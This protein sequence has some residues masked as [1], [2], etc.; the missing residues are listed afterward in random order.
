MTLEEL[1]E[2]LKAHNAN[3]EFA[4]FNE[5]YNKAHKLGT[6]KSRKVCEHAGQFKHGICG[7][8]LKKIKLEDALE[9]LQYIGEKLT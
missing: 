2:G 6:F 4:T 8:A 3:K 1:K 7:G 9:W 5:N